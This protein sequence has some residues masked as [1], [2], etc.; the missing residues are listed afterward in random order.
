MPSS[1]L[2]VLLDAEPLSQVI[3]IHDYIQLVFQEVRLNLYNV[4]RVHRDGSTL[5]ESDL[6]WADELR[7]LIEQRVVGV[8][9]EHAQFLALAF[10]HGTQ[11]LVSMRQ[12]DARGP[13]A[14]ELSDDSG[15]SVVEQNL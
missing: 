4:V 8:S 5:S 3:F 12:E 1:M 2:N 7:R 14:F 9:H 15:L 10:E 11:V 6:G 13:E